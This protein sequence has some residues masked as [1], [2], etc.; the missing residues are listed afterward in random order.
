MSWV[1][2]PDRVGRFHRLAGR[3]FQTDGAIKLKESSPK[4]F[5]LRF[6]IFKSFSLEDGRVR[7]V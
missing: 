6:G 7:G 5:K 3:E 1:L 4:D 2:N